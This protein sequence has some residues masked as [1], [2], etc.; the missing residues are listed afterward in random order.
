[1]RWVWGDTLRLTRTLKGCSHRDRPDCPSHAPRPFQKTQISDTHDVHDLDY[2]AG[3]WEPCDLCTIYVRGTGF[4]RRICTPTD[5][6]QRVITEYV[7]SLVDDLDRDLLCPRWGKVA[8]VLQI[9]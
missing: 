7:G 9:S 8:R 4:L 5:P 1:M 3:G 6:A 2:V